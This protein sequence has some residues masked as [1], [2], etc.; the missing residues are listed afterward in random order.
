MQLSLPKELHGRM[1]T[2]NNNKESCNMAVSFSSN[3]VLIYQ[4]ESNIILL[5]P[6]AAIDEP[7]AF[8]YSKT[9]MREP[10]SSLG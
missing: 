9:S 5:T 3:S 7:L 4:K 2:Y 6:K 1:V 8:P 10:N